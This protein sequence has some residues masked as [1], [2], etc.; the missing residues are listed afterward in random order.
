MFDN[1]S[2]PDDGENAIDGEIDGFIA[3]DVRSSDVCVDGAAHLDGDPNSNVCV[4]P[5]LTRPGRRRERRP[6]GGQ[7][8]D[9]RG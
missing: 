3:R 7:P 9:R 1:D 2:G 4:D 5:K 6:D 8:D